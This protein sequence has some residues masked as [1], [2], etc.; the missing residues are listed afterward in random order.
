MS[1][2]GW[3]DL[4]WARSAFGRL[5]RDLDGDVTLTLIDVGSIGGLKDRWQLLE[6][7]VR[8]YCFDPR[9]GASPREEA[10]RIVLPFA[11]G[12][13]QGRADFYCTRFGNMSSMLR[14]NAE[15]LHRFQDRETKTEVVSVEQLEIRRLDD[16]IPG[17][18]ADAMKVDAQGAELEVLLG[19][20]RLLDSELLLAEVEVSFIER[21]IAQPL[22][23]DV[24][25]FMRSRGFDLLDLYRLRRYFRTNHRVLRTYQITPNSQSGQLAYAD[26]VFFLSDAALL[27]RL[28]RLTDARKS[29]VL[30]K[31]ILLLL[32]YGKFD[33]ALQL[34]D[35]QQSCLSES[36]QRPFALFFE[37]LPLPKRRS[38]AD[39]IKRLNR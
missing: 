32:I 1:K 20:Q 5:I 10:D 29:S 19:A 15:T 2:M 8:S 38:D 37:R 3:W 21:Y 28:D 6:G 36:L 22:F 7:R 39:R 14:P 4:L 24:V 26:A 33:R 11:V 9:E 30:V 23:G 12:R 35:E 13:A 17:S 27:S 16:V 25:A 34:F 31:A 18:A